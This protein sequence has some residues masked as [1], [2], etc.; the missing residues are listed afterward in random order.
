MSATTRS[1]TYR[2]FA[3]LALGALVVAGLATASTATT[4]S[5]KKQSHPITI[6]VDEFPPVLNNMTT[7]G[8][9]EW[10]AMIA[11]PALAR[12]YKLMPDF[13]YEPWIFAKDC[14]VTTQS[15]FTVDCQIRP[16]A[17]WSDGV[18]ITSNDFK[19]TYDTIM[20][21]KNDVVSRDGYDKILSFD[22]P[23][24]TEFQMVFKDG[25]FAP[26]R[27]L[28]AG[29][30]TTVLPQHILEGKDFNKVWNSCICDPKTKKPISSGPMMVQ[31]FTPDQ[32]ATLVPNK[33]YWGGKIATVPKV[34]FVPTRDTLRNI[35]PRLA[36]CS[37]RSVMYKSPAPSCVK[38]GS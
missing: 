32:Q 25:V 8:N 28:W 6:G 38:P 27:E 13:S 31:S 33:N 12:G 9:G 22:T 7:A 17:K 4:A 16:E 26:Y 20:D 2:T 5:A 37:P 23:S 18:P 1:V 35:W 30:S 14:E 3:A 15:P 10:T 11:G 24:P 19:F 21:K 29:A 36:T 34:V